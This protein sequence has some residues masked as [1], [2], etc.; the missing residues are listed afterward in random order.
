MRDLLLVVPSRGR[1]Q[2]VDRLWTA[3]QETCRGQTDLVVG[4][5]EDDPLLLEYSETGLDPAS[6]DL[7][8]GPEFVIESGLH[9]VVAWVNH[10]AVPRAQDYRFT[11]HI[12]DDNLPVTEGWD[13]AIMEALGKTPFAFGNDLYALR[14]PGSLCCHIFMRSEIIAALGYFGPPCLRHSYVDDVWMAWG[15]AAG[16]TFLDD[17]IIEHLHDTVGKSEPDSN[18]RASRALMG[19]DSV[20]YARYCAD[21]DGL[22]ADIRKIREAVPPW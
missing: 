7:S 1:P 2:S 9:Q 18:Y 22:A 5:D 19:A 4:L 6:G 16:I 21:D 12:G 11:G 8:G 3:M 10:L 14:P 20:A 17:V 13:V 15:K